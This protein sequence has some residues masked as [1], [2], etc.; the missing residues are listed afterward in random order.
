MNATK[1]DDY[2]ASKIQ[3]LEGLESVRKRPNMH[4]GD[5]NERGLH[6]AEEEISFANR[7]KYVMIS[8]SRERDF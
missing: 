3:K 4:I 5:T 6:P 2:N 8:S 7:D 1:K